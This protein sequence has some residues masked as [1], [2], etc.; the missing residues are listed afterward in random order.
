MILPAMIE[1]S[2]ATVTPTVFALV[3][4]QEPDLGGF[5]DPAAVIDVLTGDSHIGPEKLTVATALLRGFQ[6]RSAASPAFAALLLGGFVRFLRDLRAEATWSPLTDEEL[7]HL[8]LA[9]FLSAANYVR[10]RIAGRMVI[11]RR[12]QSKR[13]ED[14]FASLLIARPGGSGGFDWQPACGAPRRRISE[15]GEVDVSRSA[16]RRQVSAHRHPH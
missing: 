13:N 3:Q 10:P 2:L 4:Q 16:D 11:A 9:S 1:R 14:A 7:D 5:R 8:V 15:A 6:A 12:M